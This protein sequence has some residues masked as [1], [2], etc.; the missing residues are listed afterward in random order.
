MG[1]LSEGVSPIKQWAHLYFLARKHGSFNTLSTIPAPRNR[2]SDV[3]NIRSEI[4]HDARLVLQRISRCSQKRLEQRHPSRDALL[5]LARLLAWPLSLRL[6]QVILCLEALREQ[7]ISAEGKCQR[8][9]TYG[10]STKTKLRGSK[11][12][13]LSKAVQIGCQ[14][15]TAKPPARVFRCVEFSKLIHAAF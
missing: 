14:A 11:E 15:P 3:L 9:I 10:S 8:I 4:D 13:V 6:L 2:H 1:N 5:C 7:K 12:H